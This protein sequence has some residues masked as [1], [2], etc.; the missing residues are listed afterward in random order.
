MRWERGFLPGVEVKQVDRVVTRI[1]STEKTP[2]KL[3]KTGTEKAGAGRDQALED[4]DM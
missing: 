4:V 3:W 2:G 1:V